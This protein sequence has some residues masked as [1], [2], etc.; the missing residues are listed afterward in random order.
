MLLQVLYASFLSPVVM[1]AIPTCDSAQPYWNPSLTGCQA[2]KSTDCE[3]AVGAYYYMG[4]TDPT[5]G[6]KGFQCCGKFYYGFRCNA[7]GRIA[8][9][10]MGYKGFYKTIPPTLSYLTE[11]V[12]LY[13]F[14]THF[15]LELSA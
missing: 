10:D 8:V 4:G 13:T 7:D 14:Y 9:V 11:L 3:Y 2:F 5:Y 12:Q 1:A 6:R 15:A